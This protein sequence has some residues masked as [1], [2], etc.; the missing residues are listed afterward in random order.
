MSDFLH[1]KGYIGSVQYS[2][3]D[4]VLHGKLQGIGA[5]V[6]YEGED[7]KTLKQEFEDAVESY[8]EFCEERGEE[9]ERS[10]GQA[11]DYKPNPIYYQRV[12]NYAEE[13]DLSV[14][15]V[16]DKAL[17]AFLKQVA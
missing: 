8:L 2:E 5:L 14:K 15:A 16:L 13:H 10:F 9:P 12:L 7:L 17:E 1:Y 11:I 6:N 4:D 3:E